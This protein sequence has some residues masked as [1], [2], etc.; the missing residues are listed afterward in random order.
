MC[1]GATTACPTNSEET[2][3]YDHAID[4]YYQNGCTYVEVG[5]GD[6]LLEQ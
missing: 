4:F 1:T 3:I 6:E 5:D 2:A